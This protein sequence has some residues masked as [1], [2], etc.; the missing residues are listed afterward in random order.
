MPLQE[1]SHSEA[2]QGRGARRGKV[3]ESRCASSRTRIACRRM[4]GGETVHF[5]TH[6]AHDI[7]VDPPNQLRKLTLFAD[8]V[9]FTETHL[10]QGRK[11]NVW[12]PTTRS[13]FSFSFSFGLQKELL[14]RKWGV[15][16]VWVW[17]CPLHPMGNRNGHAQVSFENGDAYQ[18]EWKNGKRHGDGKYIYANG[19]R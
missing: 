14:G 4:Q 13:S 8:I 6:S 9:S 2:K 16:V 10:L 1:Q 15:G 12:E 11:L 7:R 3:R 18:G 17:L 5:S 19:D